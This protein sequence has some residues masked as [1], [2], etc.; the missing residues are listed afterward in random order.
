MLA[1]LDSLSVVQQ[2]H[3][4][5]KLLRKILSIVVCLPSLTND[6]TSAARTNHA[7][8]IGSRPGVTY[9]P[10]P[11]VNLTKCF[12]RTSMTGADDCAPISKGSPNFSCVTFKSDPN[13]D[14]Q[15]ERHARAASR[16]KI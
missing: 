1:T 10:K 6:G 7:S 2:S 9:S 14:K 4:W 5:T 16:A 3:R 15:N 13:A 8:P 12:C 11:F